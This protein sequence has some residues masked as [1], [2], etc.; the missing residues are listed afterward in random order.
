[1][2]LFSYLEASCDEELRPH[3]RETG[4]PRAALE[5]PPLRDP[6]AIRRGLNVRA[7]IYSSRRGLSGRGPLRVAARDAAGHASAFTRALQTLPAYQWGNLPRRSQAAL[8]QAGLRLEPEISAHRRGALYRL[9]ATSFVLDGEA[10]WMVTLPR[11]LI[12]ARLEPRCPSQP[13]ARE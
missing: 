2:I 5:R 13:R 8:H 1:L 7:A 3:Y 6:G 10:M 12:Y 11:V 9:R 4:S